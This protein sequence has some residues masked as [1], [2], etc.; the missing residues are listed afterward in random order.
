MAATHFPE[1]SPPTYTQ[2]TSGACF[3]PLLISIFRSPA[4]GD[5]VVLGCTMQSAVERARPSQRERPGKSQK[6]PERAGKSRRESAQRGPGDERAF[7]SR[8]LRMTSWNAG[9]RTS[10]AG[11]IDLKAQL[12]G[13]C[14]VL[15]PS[16]P[17]PRAQHPQHAHSGSAPVP[18]PLWPRLARRAERICAEDADRPPYRES[19][20]AEGCSTHRHRNDDSRTG[21]STDRSR[22]C[23]R[24][25]Y[26]GAVTEA[27]GWGGGASRV[28]G[29]R[30]EEKTG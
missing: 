24:T 12:A 7:L 6:E 4:C 3:A 10:V 27:K 13:W 5:S 28:E 25:I 20:R 26:R 9:R 30:G 23:R 8:L 1:N 18:Y 22:C 29:E 14:S 21:P 15:V 19:D 11:C 16:R 2:T 17:R